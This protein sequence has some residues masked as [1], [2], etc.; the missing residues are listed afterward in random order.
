MYLLGA[1][2]FIYLPGFI[3]GIVVGL[4]FIKN[5]RGVG[6][7][8]SCLLLGFL[9]AF[10]VSPI[11]NGT[12]SVLL[13]KYNERRD[14]KE[15]T[16][17]LSALYGSYSDSEII[18]HY[19]TNII[20]N[21]ADNLIRSTPLTSKPKPERI[22][23]LADKLSPYHPAIV[24]LLTALPEAPPELKLKMAA[25]PDFEGGYQI[26]LAINEKTPPELLKIIASCGTPRILEIVAKNPSTPVDSLLLLSKSEYGGVAYAAK[27]NLKLRK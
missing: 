3:V 19:S 21:K 20:S 7:F 4:K 15:T 17:F 26:Y 10:I 11:V 6:R 13:E 27:E 14:L 12:I 16:Y 22:P 23:L 8:I 9:F 25:K 18:K 5:V 24:G 2:L 1:T